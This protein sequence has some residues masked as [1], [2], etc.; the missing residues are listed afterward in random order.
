MPEQFRV[1]ATAS[2]RNPTVNTYR[3]SPY[4]KRNDVPMTITAPKNNKEQSLC[5]EDN[6]DDHSPYVESK[7]IPRTITAP[8][9]NKEQSLC[10]QDN[11]DDQLTAALH[12]AVA[13]ER[14]SGVILCLGNSTRMVH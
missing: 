11:I 8:K 10:S 2:R 13:V 1:V 6:I 9:D 12:E 5:N 4:E 7:H 3:Y 14:L